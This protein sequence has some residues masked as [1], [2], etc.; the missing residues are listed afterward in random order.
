MI[1]ILYIVTW[2]WP[3][4]HVLALSCRHLSEPRAG[5][6]LGGAF[7]INAPGMKNGRFAP[8]TLS[9]VSGATLLLRQQR[10]L[11]G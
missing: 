2:L 10:G 3:H 11:H 6:A 4:Q 8:S 1:N 9:P 5:Q 7:L